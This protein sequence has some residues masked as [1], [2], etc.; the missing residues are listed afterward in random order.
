M[1]VGI[2]SA[3][4][5]ADRFSTIY[6][7]ADVFAK[8]AKQDPVHIRFTEAMKDL[9]PYAMG[10]MWIGHLIRFFISMPDLTFVLIRGWLITVVA[11]NG[12]TMAVRFTPGCC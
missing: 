11:T 1:D 9:L 2:S 5:H 10:G 7:V 12:P 3:S 6:V 4:R 8:S